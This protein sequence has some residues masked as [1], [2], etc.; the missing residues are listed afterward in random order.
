MEK[1]EE[2]GTAICSQ[3]DRRVFRISDNLVLKK[4]SCLRFSEVTNL[5]FVAENT[6]IPVPKVH[7]VQWENGKLT[8]IT[9]NYMSGTQ[10]EKAWETLSSE[11][12]DSIV[13]QLQGYFAQLRNL[14]GTYIGGADGQ[15]AVAG[16]M[17]HFEGGPFESDRLFNQWLLEDV[18]KR[19]RS[20][21]RYY[22]EHA[23]TDDHEINFSHGDVARRNILVDENGR[24]T[25]ILDWELG[26]W[27]PEYWESV[28]A[29]VT[30]DPLPEWHDYLAR[31]FPPQYEKEFLGQFWLS[32]L[33]GN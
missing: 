20:V 25:A 29:H 26:G 32:K 3:H 28:R 12:K 9:M 4:G 19:V 16:N 6:T 33:S 1:N 10:L 24:I 5:R 2:E 14:K 11:Q 8:G 30:C 15:I 17:F 31:V 22:A 23:L 18:D 27:Y 21:Y 13:E 7:D